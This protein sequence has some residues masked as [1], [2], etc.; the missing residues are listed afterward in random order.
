[1]TDKIG[2]DDLAGD[3]F[4]L[5][6]RGLKSIT[7]LWRSPKTYF[8][9]ARRTDWSGRFTPSVR[10]WLSIIALTSLLQFIWIGSGSPLVEAYTQGFRDA[11]VVVAGETTVE[12]LSEIAAVWIFGIFPIVQLVLFLFLLPLFPLWGKG[13]TFSLRVRYGFAMMV[14]SASLMVFILPSMALFPPGVMSSFG[15]G[16]GLMAFLVD[17]QTAYRGGFG[18][19]VLR[20]ALRAMAVSGLILTLNITAHI[21]T[22]IAGIVFVSI[23]YGVTAA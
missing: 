3:I 16:I 15:L 4:N 7:A 17:A 5:N 21:A 22:Q 23:R 13:T 8:Q 9:A 11:G 12:E 14:P 10:L 19:S 18:G 20:R 1:M 6:I 2:V